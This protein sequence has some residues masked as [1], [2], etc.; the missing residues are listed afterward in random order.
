MTS[1]GVRDRNALAIPVTALVKPGPAVTIATPMRPVRSAS[2]C[3]MCTA[4]HSW[5]VE[6][7]RTPMRASSLQIGFTCEPGNV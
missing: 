4:A 6:T 7:M 5:R 2:A 3:A 1:S